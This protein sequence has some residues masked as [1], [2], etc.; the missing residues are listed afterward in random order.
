MPNLILTTLVLWSHLEK[1]SSEREY[2]VPVKTIL[3]LISSYF[4]AGIPQ[5]SADPILIPD[6]SFEGITATV[7]SPTLGGTNTGSIGAWSASAL[8]TVS[9]LSSVSSGDASSF[10][11]APTPDD[12]N[13]IA[14]IFLP[15][16]IGA[17][18]SLSQTLTDTFSAQSI[19]TLTVEIDQ[20]VINL[21]D[22]GSLE[23][24][25]DSTVVAS[26]SGTNL[27]TSIGNTTTGFTTVTLTYQ[28]DS[29]PPE[30]NIGIAFSAAS[31]AGTSGRAYLDNFH[32]NVA[33]IPE[34]N[35]IGLIAVSL[36]L[37]L[38]FE[39]WRRHSKITKRA[40]VDK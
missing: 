6:G 40:I 30:G 3:I 9:L 4:L 32:L 8:G 37:L 16:G 17:S 10:L 38:P 5:L 20:G 18:V 35:S 24:L 13:F 34:P 14:Q 26:L 21:L 19:Y 27:Q 31:G 22:Q 29:A 1:H 15:A 11:L 39:F 23:L 36:F 25:A 33:P 12:G 28:T 2:P 7:S